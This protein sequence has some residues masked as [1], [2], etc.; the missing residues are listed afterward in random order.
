[1]GP[2][3]GRAWQSQWLEASP[4]SSTYWWDNDDAECVGPVFPLLCRC[5]IHN[6]E[7]RYF[8]SPRDPVHKGALDLRDC[9]VRRTVSDS[10][11]FA[12]QVR[13]LRRLISSGPE[14]P[15]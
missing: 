14:T 5:I 7:L 1:M 15:L 2:G 12:F 13:S 6:G 11:F 4:E 3:A 8:E 10:G 9:E